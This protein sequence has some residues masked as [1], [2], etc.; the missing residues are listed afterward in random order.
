MCQ[1]N[2]CQKLIERVG[3]TNVFLMREMFEAIL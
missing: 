2:N 3:N 1:V